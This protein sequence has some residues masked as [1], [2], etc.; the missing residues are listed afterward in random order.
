MGSIFFGPYELHPSK[1]ICVGRNYIEH[2]HELNNERPSDPVVFLK[3]NSAIHHTLVS[4]AE[5]EIHFE[6]ELSF[7]Y[8]D[9]AICA[10]AIGLDLTKRKL[11]A[12]LKAKGLPWERAKAFNKSV[13][14]SPF[15]PISAFQISDLSLQLEINGIQRQFGHIEQL[16]FSVIDIEKSLKSWLFIENGDILMT[17]TPK[18]VGIVHPGDLFKG[19]VYLNDQLLLSH[20]WVA[21]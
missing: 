3:P 8:E 16:L 1:V 14:F 20:E 15:V 6:A 17:G 11:Q 13:V 7:L 4:Q 19:T 2:V 5:E 10:V 18:G 21:E 12:K 9:S